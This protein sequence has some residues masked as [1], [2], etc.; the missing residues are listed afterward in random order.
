MSR[1]ATP[2]STRSTARTSAGSWP[3]AASPRRRRRSPGPGTSPPG[4]PRTTATG[5]RCAACGPSPARNELTQQGRLAVRATSVPWNCSRT[6]QEPEIERHEHQDNSDVYCQPRPELVPEEQDVHADHYAYHREHVKYGGCLSSHCF[7][8]LCATKRSKNGVCVWCAYTATSLPGPA[9]AW[10][11][12]G[13]PRRQPEQPLVVG[14]S[15]GTQRSVRD[16]GP[17]GGG[18]GRS[19]SGAPGTGDERRVRRVHER[20]GGRDA[21]GAGDDGADG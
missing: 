14:G 7:V 5:T 17:D 1:C 2:T 19:E 21:A 6:L 8:L 11:A 9:H 16:R 15:A 12:K 20:S 10:D 13:L 18:D 4:S 3:G